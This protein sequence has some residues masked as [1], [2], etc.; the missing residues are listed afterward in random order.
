MAARWVEQM[1]YC[2][3]D[4]KVALMGGT[5]V[6]SSADPKVSMLAVSKAAWLVAPKVVEKVD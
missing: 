4:W 5:M 6:A 3:V 2:W 1:V